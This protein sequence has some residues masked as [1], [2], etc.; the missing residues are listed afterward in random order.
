ML[1]NK[2]KLLLISIIFLGIQSIWA[3][4]ATRLAIPPTIDLSQYVDN[5]SV[6]EFQLWGWAKNGMVAY[7]LGERFIVQDLVTDKIV[8]TFKADVNVTKG[9]IDIQRELQYYKIQSSQ[10]PPQFLPFPQAINNVEYV[11]AIENINYY[12]YEGIKNVMGYD[13]TASMGSKSKVISPVRLERRSGVLAV[14]VL[15]FLQSPFEDRL[16]VATASETSDGTKLL[17]LSSK[18]WL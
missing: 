9:F 1:T 17:W 16:L 13:I 7:S 10:E 15:G 12:P 4:E 2:T 6:D 18:S 3:S 5:I 11:V 8:R 14:H